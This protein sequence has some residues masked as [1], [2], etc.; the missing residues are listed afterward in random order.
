[1]LKWWVCKKSWV[2]SW[3]SKNKWIIESI[4]FTMFWVRWVLNPRN[5]PSLPSLVDILGLFRNILSCPFR[6]TWFMNGPKDQKG[7]FSRVF[8]L[9]KVDVVV[10]DEEQKR[11]FNVNAFFSYCSVSLLVWISSLVFRGVFI[12]FDQINQISP[13]MSLDKGCIYLKFPL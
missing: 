4:L 11:S 12:L 5:Q 8:G 9:Q 2:F 1:M 10:G 13:K 6:Y 7:P 3:N